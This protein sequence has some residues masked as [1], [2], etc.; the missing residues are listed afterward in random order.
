MVN[1]QSATCRKTINLVSSCSGVLAT[2]DS[3]G[4]LAL[5]GFENDK[6]DLIYWKRLK[7][8]SNPCEV[9]IKMKCI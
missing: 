7:I 3:F 2:S 6:Q 5:V 4:A 8:T 1:R 9:F